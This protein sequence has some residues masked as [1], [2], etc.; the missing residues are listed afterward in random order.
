MGLLINSDAEI[1]RRFF[2][3]AAKLKGIQVKYQYPID[4]TFSKYAEEDPRGYSEFK[5]ID[6]I[7]EE[8]PNMKTLKRYGWTT[9]TTDD[10]PF[11]GYFAYNTYKL[12]KGCRIEI[13]SPFPEQEGRLFVVT[14]IRSALEYPEAWACKLAPVFHKKPDPQII[15]NKISKNNDNYLSVKL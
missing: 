4:M 6:I 5:E 9:E 8:N 13:P 11:L 10:L 3:E 14:E 2:S 1:L 7:F 15:E 12:A